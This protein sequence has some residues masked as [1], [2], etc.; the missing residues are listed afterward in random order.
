M[1]GHCKHNETCRFH[2]NGEI[3]WPG[4]Q[5]LAFYE[6]KCPMELV[7]IHKF[8]NKQNNRPW[9][10]TGTDWLTS[11]QRVRNS[12]QGICSEQSGFWTH[13]ICVLQFYTVNYH[14]INA[15]HSRSFIH[16]WH[17]AL[18]NEPQTSKLQDVL[19]INIPENVR[20]TTLK[21]A[22]GTSCDCRNA[23]GWQ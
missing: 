17:S 5:L 6:G 15:Q 2:K 10:H 1:A 7:D 11:H 4:E 3:S 23:W 21:V 9:H 14:S 12:L 19:S 13:F 16:Q 8:V 22:A 20:F 18:L